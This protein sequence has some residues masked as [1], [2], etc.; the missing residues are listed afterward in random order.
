MCSYVT[1]EKY[2]FF[3]IYENVVFYLFDK[4]MLTG[5][6]LID[7]QKA[8]DTIDHEILLP[9]LKAIK[10]SESTIKWFKSFLSEGIFLVNLENK[11]SDFEEISCAVPQ[12]SILGP[13]L[14]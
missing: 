10:F 7:L 13:L 9:K 5:M 12:G 6:I 3:N 4:G 2:T 1:V 14:F 11:L 8:F